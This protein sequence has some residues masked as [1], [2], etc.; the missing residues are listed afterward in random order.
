MVL[1]GAVLRNDLYRASAKS[2]IFC[3]VLV[4]DDAD[5]FYR[6]FVWRDDRS[7]APGD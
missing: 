2:S 4:G 6:I 5:F 7:A 3:V 1:V